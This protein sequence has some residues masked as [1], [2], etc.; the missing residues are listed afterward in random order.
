[1]S[2][3]FSLDTIRIRLNQPALRA[4]ERHLQIQRVLRGLILE[5]L[6][7]PGSKLP[8][9]RTLAKSL[10]V[11]RDTV[12]NAYIQLQRDGYI[13][14]KE[15]SGSYVA[16][17][18][19][20]TLY[21]Q[22]QLRLSPPPTRS[23][24]DGL[25][26]R[27]QRLLA[28]GGVVDHQTPIAFATG[29]PETRSFPIDVWLRLHRKVV[30]ETPHHTLLHGDP[31]GA[32][33]LREAIATY[34]N[35]E[36]GAQV[37]ADHILIL[38]STRQ[39]LFL[40]AQMLVDPG[41]SILMENP[42]YYGAKKAFEAAQARVRPIDVDEHGLCIDQIHADRS[43]A[44]CVYVTPSHQYPTGVTLSLERRLALI[45]WAHKN[46]GWIIEDD[47]D[48]EFHYDGLPTAC[49]QGLDPY[50]RTLYIGTFSKTLFPGLRIGYM[51]LPPSLMPVM[52]A[53][54]SIIDGHTPQNNQL[55]LARFMADGHYNAHVRM[56]RQLYGAR[57]A[58]LLQAIDTH[59]ADVVSPI[60]PSK[61]GGLMLSCRL[62]PAYD[63][64]TTIAQA[65]E[66]GILL[67]GLSRLYLGPTAEQ[68]WVLGYGSLTPHEIDTCMARLQQA[69]T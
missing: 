26:K 34:L 29:L 4:L 33:P 68:G 61:G 10:N 21:G 66:A 36:R 48:S 62:D 35:L 2:K 54:R 39:A 8:A 53:A 52:V 40:C 32:A 60:G 47:Y 19:G 44:R 51:A 12:E 42:G 49:V 55:T 23:P 50:Q 20:A 27:G 22:P 43:G 56:M 58:A 16:A 24:S 45:E 15:G 41:G 5:G 13:T 18:I 64:A 17:S 37:S 6:L 63:E 1:M 38:S 9:T 57:K 25:S 59:L 28:A 31:Q 65:A 11:A 69:L 14:R 30:Q 3:S 46:Q 67:P 7:L